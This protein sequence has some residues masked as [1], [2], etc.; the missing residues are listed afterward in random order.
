MDSI[1]D[2]EE[3]NLQAEPFFI[4]SSFKQMSVMLWKLS[5]FFFPLRVCG[6]KKDFFAQKRQLLFLFNFRNCPTLDTLPLVTINV[7]NNKCSFLTEYSRTIFFFFFLFLAN[8]LEATV[9]P[10]LE[11]NHIHYFSKTE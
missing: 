9:Y 8:N 5:F 1:G 7:F 3:N 4:T 11:S 6:W 10:H 2:I